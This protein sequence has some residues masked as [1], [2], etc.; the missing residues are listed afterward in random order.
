MAL[1]SFI[2]CNCFGAVFLCDINKLSTTLRLNQP[3]LNQSP[4]QPV[5]IKTRSHHNNILFS[6]RWV[7]LNKENRS[8]LHR[9]LPKLHSEGYLQLTLEITQPQ[10]E[11][12]ITSA[13]HPT[14]TEEGEIDSDS[15]EN[16]N[17]NNDVGFHHD[18][19]TES[20][21]RDDEEDS[22]ASTAESKQ[23]LAACK[24]NC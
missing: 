6:I 4:L 3:T 7:V 17:D 12:E 14:S 21:D 1:Y 10:Q 16:S 22:L 15:D 5:V 13:S 19:N 20:V 9:S 18:N 23:G 8:D 24:K 2:A 11:G